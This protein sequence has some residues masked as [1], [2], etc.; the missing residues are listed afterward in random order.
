MERDDQKN[1][2]QSAPD[3]S[4]TGR[5]QTKREQQQSDP[6]VTELNGLTDSTEDLEPTLEDGTKAPEKEG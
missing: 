1:S 2:P 4:G 6:Q 5:D 3:S